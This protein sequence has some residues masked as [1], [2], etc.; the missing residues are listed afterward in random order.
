MIDLI[1]DIINYNFSYL[2]YCV[3]NPIVIGVQFIEL[4]TYMYIQIYLN[5]Y[6]NIIRYKDLHI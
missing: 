3:S 6:R 5:L 4:K 1:Y 2:S